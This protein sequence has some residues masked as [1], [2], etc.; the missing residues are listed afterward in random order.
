M[1]RHRSLQDRRPSPLQAW[2]EAE[3][4]EEEDE[5]CGCDATSW[6]GLL[7]NPLS[8]DVCE[9]ISWLQKQSWSFKD[10]SQFSMSRKY[11]WG[12]FCSSSATWAAK[13]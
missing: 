4:E 5:H 6:L 1:L 9:G 10:S 7:F 2:E 12:S 3:E 8:E 13:A 11:C